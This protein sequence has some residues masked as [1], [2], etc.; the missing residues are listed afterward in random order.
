[1]LAQDQLQLMQGVRASV[2]KYLEILLM[3]WREIV[4]FPVVCNGF[5]YDVQTSDFSRDTSEFC[6]RVVASLV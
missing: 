1:M 3:L 2:S 5:Q 4:R 6:D